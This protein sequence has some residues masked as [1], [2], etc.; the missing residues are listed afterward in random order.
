MTNDVA[1]VPLTSKGY[2]VGLIRSDLMMNGGLGDDGRP[3][4][5]TR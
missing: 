4:D 3:P 1:D 2:A 5:L